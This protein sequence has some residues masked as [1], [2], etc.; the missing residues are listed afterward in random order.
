MKKQYVSLLAVILSVS[1]FLFSCGDKMNKNTGELTFDSIRVNETAHLFSDTA[2]P[3]CNLV[4]SFTYPVK[5]SDEMLKD[6]L[7]AYFFAACFGDKYI[8]MTAPEAVKEYT[9]TYINEYRRDLEPMYAEDEKNKENGGSIGSWYSYYKTIKSSI[10]FYEKNLLVYHIYYDE[11]T[12]G[13]HGI[14]ANTFLNM[15]LSTMRPLHLSDLFVEGYQESMTE[16]I[17]N[18]LMAVNNVTTRD[19]LEDLGYGSTGEIAP[20]E[21]FF[22]NKEGITFYYNVYDI[23]PYS[24]GP[25]EVHIPFEMMAHLF[26]SNPIIAEL[27]QL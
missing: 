2:K 4:I 27:K 24:M 5:S 1:G 25:V 22:L 14:Y 12:G 26:G 3:A 21:N 16:L 9:Q 23:T 15:D 19:A 11:F 18:R 10:S 6:S 17:W 8:G 13:A 7:N 20:T